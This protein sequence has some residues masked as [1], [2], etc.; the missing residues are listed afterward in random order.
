MKMAGKK[1]TARK[2]RSVAAAALHHGG[3]VSKTTK[4]ALQEGDVILPREVVDYFGVD[5]L[6]LLREEAARSG[7]TP[8]AARDLIARVRRLLKVPTRKPRKPK[9]G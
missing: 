3:L 4:V 5:F 9:P 7:S 6:D 8:K 2:R 1:R